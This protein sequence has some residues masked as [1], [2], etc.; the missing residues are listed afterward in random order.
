LIIEAETFVHDFFGPGNAALP[1][2]DLSGPLGP[3]VQPYLSPLLAGIRRAMIL[4]RT[5]SNGVT[6]AYIVSW[7]PAEAAQMRRLIEAFVGYSLVSFDGR[8]SRLRDDDPVDCAVIALVGQN[9]TYVLRPSRDKVAQRALWRRLATLRDL[10]NSRPERVRAIPRPVGRLLAEFRAAIA[11]GAAQTSAELLDELA[12]AGGISPQNLAYLRVHRLGRL[13]RSA[14]LLRM[15]EFDDVVAS[16]P[17][18]EVAEAILAAWVRVEFA[19]VDFATS[20]D[21]TLAV[22]GSS[23]LAN[24]LARL[25]G[26]VDL[27]DPAVSLAAAIICL[28]R[29]EEHLASR[30]LS[31]ASLPASVTDAVAVIAEPIRATERLVATPPTPPPAEH[32]AVTPFARIV[33]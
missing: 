29:R 30:L 14:E 21:V 32:P 6:D 25:C 18:T 24:Q 23:Q 11:G 31:A 10:L 13:G 3:R 8:L 28:V 22:S 16:R 9:T 1:G 26:Q 19:D 4:P 5:H 20:E 33:G 27:V 17:P 7:D 2:A 15:P 12:L